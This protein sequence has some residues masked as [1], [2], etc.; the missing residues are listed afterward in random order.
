MKTN[1]NVAGRHFRPPDART[2]CNPLGFVTMAARYVM[3]M[4]KLLETWP[5]DAAA[6]VGPHIASLLQ[7]MST[8]GNHYSMLLPFVLTTFC[9][10]FGPYASVSLGARCPGWSHNCLLWWAVVSRSSS[11]KME[12]RR[13]L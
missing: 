3:D 12:S 4:Q 13:A 7:R 5:V 10:V 6:L 2:S 9:I 11:G 1:L 8:S